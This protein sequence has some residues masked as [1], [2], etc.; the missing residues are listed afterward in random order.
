MNF[1]KAI[2]VGNVTQD[3]EV[4]TTPSGDKVANFSVA[5]NRIWTD[6]NT[7]EKQQKAEFHNVV[8][9]RRLAEIAE[10]YL[11]KGSLVL[12][13]GRIETRSWEGQDGNTRYKTE[14]VAETMQLGPKRDGSTGSPQ[15]GSTLRETSGQAGSGQTNSRRAEKLSS[16][17]APD[18]E[19]L[20]TIDADTPQ[21]DDDEID[22]K[23][24]PF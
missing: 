21:S 18:D 2:I 24:I 23:D 5:S 17:D 3:P 19:N 9:W 16:S 12:I 6:K 13:E 7:G 20:P 4:R 22:V 1:N 8:V 10:Q 14:I 15:V 11:N